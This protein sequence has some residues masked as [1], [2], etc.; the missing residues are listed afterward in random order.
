MFR[1]SRLILV[2]T[3]L[4]SSMLFSQVRFDANFE[5]GNMNTVSTSDS[6]TYTV[7]TKTDIG[8]RWFYFRMTGVQ[9]KFIRVRVTSS[10]VKRAVYSYN[11]RDWIRFTGGESPTT[12]TFEKT[13]TSDTVYAAYYIPYTLTHLRER[14]AVWAA[15]PMVAVDTLG[16]TLRGLPIYEM[17]ITDSSVPDSL[18][19]HI[20][21][22]SRTHPGETPT[23]VQ[24]EGIMKTLLSGKDVT[25]YYLK[26]MVFHMIPFTN[27]DGVYYGRSRTN[28]DGVDVESNW[29]RVDSLTSQEVLILKARMQQINQ[30]NTV[31]VFLNLH[32]QASPFC[33]FWIH[34]AS[35]TS[36][37][38]FRQEM[39]FSNI[40]ISDNPYFV[41]NDY[42]FSNLS[43][44]FPEG[45]QWRNWG[46]KIMAL[47]YE[48]PYDYYSSGELVTNENLEYIGERTLYSIAEYLK[49]SHPKH[50]VLDND[51]VPS[52]W[53]GDTTGTDFFGDN[54]QYSAPG[55]SS[56]PL[57]YNSGS[58]EPGDYDIYGWWPVNTGF[59]SNTKISMTGGGMTK[60]KIVS[61]KFGHGAWNYLGA[62]TLQ[63]SGEIQI[64]VAD[65]GNGMVA[66]DA[67]RIIYK[68]LPTSVKD[69]PLAVYDFNLEQNYPNPFNSQTII[70]YALQNEGAVR[71]AIY[72][73]I[74]QEV[75][76]LVH[77]IKPAG[78][79][80]TAF[81]GASLSSGIYY[82]R[83]GVN[84][85][86][87]TKPM[88]L[89]K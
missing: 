22:H 38:F 52:F 76:L 27:P 53:T 48:T 19:H 85:R 51:A 11:N 17:T 68:G 10:D 89:L 50:M 44:T 30:M 65:T 57:E 87:I 62:L 25:D 2:F 34:T 54:Y 23:S 39:Q 20:W 31:K 61:Q 63:N 84:G 28:F 24:F 37:R 83:L 21:I 81:S 5:S 70:R 77:E 12:N 86:Y 18:K 35:S 33:T 15:H 26:R 36:A 3:F 42:S 72:N 32:S 88:V 74:G 67:F 16:H 58:I 8:G 56:G 82:M 80:E 1:F 64:T 78:T 71:L 79:F 55:S 14:L 47:T 6:V 46:E 59:A 7:T 41:Y 45:W 40:N 43:M 4:L 69:K 66:A 60:E 9:N 49:I 13:Y 73:S 29:N 75:A